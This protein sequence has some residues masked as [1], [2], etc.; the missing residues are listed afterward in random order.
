MNISIKKASI[1]ESI[2]HTENTGQSVR[3]ELKQ[4]FLS[5]ENMLDYINDIAFGG[6][7]KVSS[8]SP[9]VE[10]ISNNNINIIVDYSDFVLIKRG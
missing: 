2:I 3:Y 8:I 9:F 7:G 6:V 1:I 10:A 5:G 4:K